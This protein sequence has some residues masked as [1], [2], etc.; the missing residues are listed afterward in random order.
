MSL[1]TLNI[2]KNSKT[3]VKL[4]S[5]FILVALLQLGVGLFALSSMAKLNHNV[6]KMY[7]QNVR[8]AEDMG[9]IRYLLQDMRI[10]SND[11][12]T[13][14]LLTPE[15]SAGIEDTR[16]QVEELAQS[17]EK[18]ELTKGQ[19][20][21]FD[22]F[23]SNWNKFNEEFD[24]SISVVNGNKDAKYDE[25]NI[26]EFFFNIID[27]TEKLEN[28]DNQEAAKFSKEAASL[29]SK[30]KG[31]TLLNILL[32]FA[33]C[34][35]FGFFIARMISKPLNSMAILVEKVADGDLTE[36]SSIQTKDEVG[37]LAR[38]VNRM[39][40]NLRETVHHISRASENLSASSSQVS[41]STEQIASAST[42]QA[43][44][45]QTMSELLKELSDAINSVANNTE[46]AA[47]LSN[48]AISLAKEGEIVVLS[49]VKASNQV[50][51]Q[52]NHLEKD[53]SKVGD[54]IDVINEIAEQTNLLALNAAIEAARAGEQGRGFAVVA[55]EVRRLAERS[56]E[57]TSQITAII[58][59]MQKNTSESVSAVEEGLHLT[60]RSGEAFEEIIRMI[61]ETGNKVTEIAGAS[62]E[63]AAQSVE[64]LTFIENI[65]AT[66]QEA[67]A[68][69]EETAGTAQSLAD[70]SV[71]LNESVAAFK[72]R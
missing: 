38:S 8:A 59:G 62:E 55:D 39:I 7:E 60:R 57:A 71:E 33:I 21:E 41:A 54:I 24:Y 10:K 70:L 2:F 6:E 30:S 32:T 13:K 15:L 34:I 4:L 45:V 40:L 17:Y 31:I 63:Q 20:V 27:S 19:Q 50:S 67:A 26:A 69:S 64:V 29:Y 43:V 28:M 36:T 58:E 37:L 44:S 25:T 68:S 42:E 53:S 46:Q 11:I 66:T 49:S 48:Q 35:A 1:K 22:R 52:M 5:A 65:S 18:T 61:N 23:Y 16:G 72:L 14:R 12:L 56:G 9:K 51:E 3:S 47:A